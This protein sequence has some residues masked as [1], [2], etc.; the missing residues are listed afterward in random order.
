MDCGE[1]SL[2]LGRWCDSG[3]ESEGDCSN[4]GDIYSGDA[5]DREFGGPGNHQGITTHG[6]TR[7]ALT[8]ASF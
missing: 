1:L 7:I 5:H 2:S 6:P 4:T 3:T 8:T